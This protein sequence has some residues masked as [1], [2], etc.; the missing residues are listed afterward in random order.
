MNR[1][2]KKL[3]DDPEDKAAMD[4]INFFKT[5][6]QR[7]TE[8]EES[9]EWRTDNMEYDLRTN[10]MIANKCSDRVYAQHLYAAL[11]NNDFIK[12]DVWPIL[13]DKRWSC[14]WRHAGGIIANIREEGD[15]ID[16]YCSGIK[17]M[18][19]LDDDQFRELTKEQ[20]LEH[21]EKHAF[22]S[23]STVTDE[24]RQDLLTL[25]WLVADNAE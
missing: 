15:Y 20:Q 6:I 21:L 5:D 8:L 12:N 19:D 22:V 17:D 13:T 24:I 7:R 11:C 18:T 23:E 3:V 9:S 16:W 14:S 4:M 10:E 1:Y 25:G 2:E